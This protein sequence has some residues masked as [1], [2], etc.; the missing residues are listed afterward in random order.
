MEIHSPA[1]NTDSARGGASMQ[2]AGIF[3][4]RTLLGIIFLMQGYG[5]IFTIGVGRVYEMFFKPFE[6]TFLPKWIII[7]TAYY[8]SYIEMIGGFL[9]I[10]G[11]FRKYTLYLLAIDLLI[12]SF[13]HGLMEPVWDL[14]HVMPRAIL[15]TALMLLPA[16]W[17][18]WNTDSF[19]RKK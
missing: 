15:L 17:D 13:G 14:S 9:L 10:I 2:T 6:T 8:T 18:K 11:L 19:T 4:I 5:K 16:G 7:S 3:F 1:H 12:V